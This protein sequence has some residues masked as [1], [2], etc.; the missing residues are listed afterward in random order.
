MALSSLI[1]VTVKGWIGDDAVVDA[2]E[3]FHGGFRQAASVNN[4]SHV[5]LF[6]P[7]GSGKTLYMDF[8]TLFTESQFQ[9]A[10]NFRRHDTALTN[11]LGVE[12]N[13]RSGSAIVSVAEVRSEVLTFLKGTLINPIH[14]VAAQTSVGFGIFTTIKHKFNPAVRIDEGDGFLMVP[15]LSNTALNV[16]FQWREKAI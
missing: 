14:I 2:N 10:I 12:A 8:A 1:S 6:N 9:Y 3:A 13:K 7:I 15:D 11:N 4:F 5:Q 16:Y